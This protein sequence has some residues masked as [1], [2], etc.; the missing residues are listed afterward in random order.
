M[1]DI[2][3][4]S[5]RFQAELLLE[6]PYAVEVMLEHL[7]ERYGEIEEH[8]FVNYDINGIMHRVG[9]GA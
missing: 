2:Y 6:D 4:C 5:N 7:A 3:K 9:M 8:F 1:E